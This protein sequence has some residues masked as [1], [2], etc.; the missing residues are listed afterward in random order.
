MESAAGAT[1][2]KLRGRREIEPGSVSN[3]A[4]ATVC[5]KMNQEHNNETFNYR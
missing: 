2:M 1:I 3:P 5:T 4:E